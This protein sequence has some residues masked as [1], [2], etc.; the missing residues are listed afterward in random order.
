MSLPSAP[1][2]VRLPSAASLPASVSI[3]LRS[4][5]ASAVFRFVA[6]VATFCCRLALA[7]AMTLSSAAFQPGVEDAICASVVQRKL[8]TALRRSTALNANSARITAITAKPRTV[9]T[10]SSVRQAGAA[11]ADCALVRDAFGL[12]ARLIATDFAISSP[13]GRV[14]SV[15]QHFATV[16][17]P[18]IHSDFEIDQK[19]SIPAAARLLIDFSI[20]RFRL[21][22]KPL[23]QKSPGREPS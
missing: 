6:N 4:V 13:H 1:A 22:T 2:T 9:A 18:A 17:A 8:E 21:L 19:R 16:N 5:P 7:S 12:P 23:H 14:A 15:L 3:A 20:D 11:A 10:Q